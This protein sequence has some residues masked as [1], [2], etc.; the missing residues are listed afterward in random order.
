MVQKVH[1]ATKAGDKLFCDGALV[2]HQEQPGRA[3]EDS[4][5]HPPGTLPFGGL[6]ED[7]SRGVGILDPSGESDTFKVC[8]LDKTCRAREE[9]EF[10]HG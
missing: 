8:I 1:A 6:S 9:E 2:A 3:L 10:R 5:G 7:S 4:F